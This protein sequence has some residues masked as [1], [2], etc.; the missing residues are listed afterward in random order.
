MILQFTATGKE[1][2]EFKSS[3]FKRRIRPIRLLG[4]CQMMVFWISTTWGTVVSSCV[5]STFRVTDFGSS[6]HQSEE[7]GKVSIGQFQGF[8]QEKE[9]Y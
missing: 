4:K 5:A 7:E 6:A 9:K 8:W 3:Y 1:N 2:S